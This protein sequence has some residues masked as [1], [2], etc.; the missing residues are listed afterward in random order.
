MVL[1]PRVCTATEAQDAGMPV[2]GMDR[3]R[4]HSIPARWLVSRKLGD[5]GGGGKGSECY[6]LPEPRSEGLKAVVLL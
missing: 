3:T 6:K 1:C 4:L 5:H 2:L